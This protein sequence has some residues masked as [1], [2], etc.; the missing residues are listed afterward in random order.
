[1]TL[2]GDAAKKFMAGAAARARQARADRLAAAKSD[3]AARGKEPFDLGKLDAMCD[4]SHD[5][6]LTLPAERS[7]EHEWM[8]YVFYT[9]LMT[10]A[11]YA[12]RV[13]EQNLWSR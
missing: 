12:A 13:T 8:Y 3:A 9:E 2:T 10:L 6:V 4:T 11:E 1:M 7:A 5:G